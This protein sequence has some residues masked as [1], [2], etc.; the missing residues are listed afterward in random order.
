MENLEPRVLRPIISLR[1]T[2]K[3]EAEIAEYKL[4]GGQVGEVR[5]VWGNTTF[6]GKKS[7]L[8]ATLGAD[9]KPVINLSWL[10]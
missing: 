9:N 4:Q 8:L 10:D 5:F 3:C 2:G 1:V 6:L 7:V